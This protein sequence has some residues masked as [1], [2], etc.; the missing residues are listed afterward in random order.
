MIQGYGTSVMSEIRGL[1]GK[2]PFTAFMLAAGSIAIL[3]APPFAVFIGEISILS[4]A[5]GDGL[6]A[7]AAVM[8]LLIIVVFAGFLRNVLPMFS[9]STEKDVKELRGARIVPMVLLFVAVLLFGLFMPEQMREALES[10]ATA[11]TGG[12]F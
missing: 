3:G 2:M 5:F 1:R 10:I 12:I 11:V 7:I 9:G 8:I 4:G 6:Y